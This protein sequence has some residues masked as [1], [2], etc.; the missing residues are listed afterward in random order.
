MPARVD[1]LG[2]AALQPGPRS[3]SCSGRRSSAAA[4]SRSACRRRWR[5]AAFIG[6][7]RLAAGCWPIW[8]RPAHARDPFLDPRLFADRVFSS[9]ALISLLTGYGLATA[10]VGGAVFVDR[11]LYG[12]P[13]EQRVVLGALAGAMAVGRSASGFLTRLSRCAC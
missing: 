5:S 11:V 7:R 9:A 8:H 1:V 10:I 3:A 2:A 4:T 6:G 12:G 13:D